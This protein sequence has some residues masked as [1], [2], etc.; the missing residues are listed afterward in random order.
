MKLSRLQ[1]EYR[2]S[3][4]KL[5]KHI[6]R[7][8][9]E[10]KLFSHYKVYQEYPVNL[11]NTS[12]PNAQHK[13]D[14]VILDLAIV[15]EVHGQQHYSA[16]SFGSNKDKAE[17]FYDLKRRDKKKRDAA[18]D[19]GFTYLE[20]SYDEIDKVDDR[21]IWDLWKRNQNPRKLKKEVSQFKQRLSK[22]RRDQYKRMKALLKGSD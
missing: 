14:W 18:I 5:H 2:D 3:A 6:G 16:T 19:A 10:S 8:L 1:Y 21:Y 12:Y 17:L 4:S 11:I 13:F 15:I 22:Y 20:I 9:R 7:V